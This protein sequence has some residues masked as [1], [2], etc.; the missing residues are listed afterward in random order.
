V[1]ILPHSFHPT[2]AGGGDFPT[3]LFSH[4][5]CGWELSPHPRRGWGES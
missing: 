4:P 3:Q 2:P 5:R 1:A